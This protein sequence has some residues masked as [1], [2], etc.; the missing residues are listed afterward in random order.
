MVKKSKKEIEEL[1][2]K[3]DNGDAEAAYNYG[4]LLHTGYSGVDINKKE[5]LK[6]Y[7]L[8]VKGGNDARA[9]YN[10]AL[11][12][13]YGSRE[14]NIKVNK[15]KAAKFYKI[16]ADND[17]EKAIY[18]Y[19]K[20]LE[21]GD[22]IDVDKKE[23]EKYYSKNNNVL[24]KKMKN[25]LK[26]QGY[27]VGDLL[28][29]GGEGTVFSATDPK[30]KDIVVKFPVT[31]KER[32]ILKN[33]KIKDKEKI[34]EYFNIIG[35]GFT[36]VLKSHKIKINDKTYLVETYK[37]REMDLQN[38][39]NKTIFCKNKTNLPIM[40]I[41][42][43]L[44]LALEAAHLKGLV[45]ADIK[46]ENVLINKN[47]RLKLSD[48]GFTNFASYFKKKRSFCGTRVYMAD[49]VLNGFFHNG[50][51]DFFINEK[52]DVYSMGILFLE[53]FI[54]K[55]ISNFL[56]E[57]NGGEEIDYDNYYEFS[58][59]KSDLDKKINLDD[60]KL[61]GLFPGID[62][63][64][65]NK[66]KQI[67]IKEKILEILRSML[68][69]NYKER[70]TIFE[71]KEKFIDLVKFMSKNITK[72][73]E[74]IN[75][76]KDLNIE[77]KELIKLGILNK[78]K[79]NKAA[80]KFKSKL[81]IKINKDNLSKEA[82][83]CLKVLQDSIDKNGNIGQMNYDDFYSNME[84]LIIAE[85]RLE[86]LNVLDKLNH[87]DYLRFINSKNRVENINSLSLENLIYINPEMIEH[88]FVLDLDER[89]VFELKV[90][91][92]KLIND[93]GLYH[94]KKYKNLT[95]KEKEDLFIKYNELEDRKSDFNINYNALCKENM[96]SKWINVLFKH[97]CK[98][99]D[100]FA[101]K[102]LFQDE[103]IRKIIKNDIVK[104][105]PII[106]KCKNIEVIEEMLDYLEENNIEIDDNL[107][108]NGFKEAF[109][110]GNL[111]VIKKLIL[112]K[113]INSKITEKIL[114]EGFKIACENGHINIVDSM[115]KGVLK[116][117]GLLEKDE[118]FI[119]DCFNLVC[120]KEY[121]DIAKKMLYNIDIGHKIKEKSI[122]NCFKMACEKGKI[123]IFQNLLNDDLM[124]KQIIFCDKYFLRECF[125]IAC[126][127]GHMN[128]V[129]KLIDDKNVYSIL[130]EKTLDESF[131]LAKNNGNYEKLIKEI[132][133]KNGENLLFYSLRKGN[134][135]TAKVLFD[136]NINF[137]KNKSVKNSKNFIKNFK[138]FIKEE[139]KIDIGN[140]NNEDSI[141]WNLNNLVNERNYIGVKKLELI[142]NILKEKQLEKLGEKI[143]NKT[144]E[145]QVEKL[146]IASS[147]IDLIPSKKER[148]FSDSNKDDKDEH[149]YQNSV[150][151]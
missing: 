56:E 136:N 135:K 23:A 100:E 108:S 26:K 33:Q 47:G 72:N 18:E 55:S 112:N 125:K 64:D 20:M 146:N 29:R 150:N 115:L 89:E 132:M 130:D 92:E 86:Y 98:N 78:A 88:L 10:I 80:K 28:G 119:N 79:I 2:A 138:K 82:K 68:K 52:S 129:N 44:I 83:N 134:I 54:Q 51:K 140:E 133:E 131:N 36:K 65:E 43:Q 59:L 126:E 102:F 24:I 85:N 41:M 35:N 14:E 106:F 73:N 97:A 58:E 114:K 45:L 4:Y 104:G 84:K 39:L 143:T 12:L 8:A 19:A 7:N 144:M 110:A 3:A 99:K 96:L 31:K 94:N 77:D 48:F 74:N 95:H 91:H 32:K 87:L 13:Y 27:Q 103:D 37:R 11:I 17:N 22:G 5:A 15:K 124:L 111:N 9:A 38:K 151:V 117:T 1:K 142:L 109:E 57:I 101:I 16:A 139:L 6:Y 34:N 50:T 61:N 81:N 67:E 42:A 71:I 90:D 141:A 122:K 123:K 121:A 120:D 118:N 127:N 62:F 116:I 113:K 145:K 46:P 147:E 75:I 137:G 63:N 76:K 69:S 60:I 70:S 53:I 128:I 25:E 149:N 30:G 93:L 148:S 40:P 66:D 21:N 49:E 105:F 107:L